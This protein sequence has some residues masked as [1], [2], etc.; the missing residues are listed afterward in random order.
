MLITRSGDLER[1]PNPLVFDELARDA[2]ATLVALRGLEGDLMVSERDGQLELLAARC[3]GH[4]G[5]HRL[6]PDGVTEG[7]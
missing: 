4:R 3:V 1:L 5:R 2:D 6:L 7:T